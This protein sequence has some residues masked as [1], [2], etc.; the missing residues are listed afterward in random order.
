M[1]LTKRL[2]KLLFGKANRINTLILEKVQPVYEITAPVRIKF[3]CP[4]T[5]T[6]YRA[7]TLFTKEP[8]TIAWIDSFNTGDILFDIGANVGVYSLYAATRGV[9]VYS[10]EPESL[11]YAILNRNI[12]IN[13]LQDKI[14]SFNIALSDA[15]KIDYLYLNAFCAGNALHSF[16]KNVD[17]KRETFIPD[18]KQTALSFT[19]DF[20][21]KTYRIPFPTHLKIDVDGLERLIIN[22]SM[23][24]IADPR[25]SS[26]L[27]ELNMNVEEDCQVVDIMSKFG[28]H[29]VTGRFLDER[30]RLR[31]PLISYTNDNFLFNYIFMRTE[32]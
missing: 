8:E 7:K 26:V 28:Y 5:M 27:V 31:D 11:N 21:I 12:Y 14:S 9:T 13:S 17:F 29:V 22:G 18:F 16:G 6:L 10:F 25:L 2:F 1:N 32:S 4:N 23:G 24:T 3:Y 30:C 15:N 20:F 19:L